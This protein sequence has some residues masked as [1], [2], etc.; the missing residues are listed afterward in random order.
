METDRQ[1][2]VSIAE[3]ALVAGTSLVQFAPMPRPGAA[4]SVADERA[5]PAQH[6][7][8]LL[9]ALQRLESVVDEEVSALRTRKVVDF[10]QYSRAKNRGLLELVRTSRTAAEATHDPVVA[11]QIA[12][13]RAKLKQNYDMLRLH[14]EAVRA[15]SEIIGRAIRA[16]ESDGT[17]PPTP[18]AKEER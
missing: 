3:A 18:T 2:G 12:S 17:Y 9:R 11:A 13:L 8:A 7:A 6:A 5:N 14:F 1:D 16:A 10:D 15:V 4:T